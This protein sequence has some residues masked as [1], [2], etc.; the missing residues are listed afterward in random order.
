MGV[1]PL[2]LWASFGILLLRPCNLSNAHLWATNW[3]T[4]KGMSS[5]WRPSHPTVAPLSPLLQTVPFKCVWPWDLGILCVF[6]FKHNNA[7][8]CSLALFSSFWI[9]S[10]K[11]LMDFFEGRPKELWDTVQI[12]RKPGVW[13]SLAMSCVCLQEV[14]PPSTP[15]LSLLLIF[16]HQWME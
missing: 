7:R 11:P 1:V 15:V 3:R 14:T 16:L 13:H 12:F 6:F 5:S 10:I 2:L 4:A 9:Y 8:A